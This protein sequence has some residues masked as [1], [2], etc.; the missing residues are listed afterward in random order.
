MIRRVTG[1]EWRELRDTR[2][3][4]LRDAPDAFGGTYEASVS[5][6][7]EW[8]RDWA[9]RSAESDEQAMFLAWD[10]SR[11]AG[12]SGTYRHEGTWSLIAMWVE[13]GKRGAGLGRQL[14]DAVTGFVRAQGAAEIFLGVTEGNDVARSLYERYGF[15]PTGVQEPLREGSPL[16]V[17]QLRFQL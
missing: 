2:L 15:E 4:S 17:H 16:V 13:P 5:R 8:W 1:D 12:I 7:D 14:V 9:K 10:E 3:A 6:T 11:P